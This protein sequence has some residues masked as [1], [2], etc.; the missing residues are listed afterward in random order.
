[1]SCCA[2]AL[3]PLALWP[4]HQRGSGTDAKRARAS[5][6][7]PESRN[8]R[9]RLATFHSIFTFDAVMVCASAGILKSSA[10]NIK[11]RIRTNISLVCHLSVHSIFH[12]TELRQKLFVTQSFNGVQF[13]RTPCGEKAKNQTNHAGKAK[14]NQHHASVHIK[15]HFQE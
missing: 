7:L 12:A 2:G 5:Q 3:W 6:M 9:K 1:M 13:C 10:R 11:E 8:R 14:G 4:L 15:R